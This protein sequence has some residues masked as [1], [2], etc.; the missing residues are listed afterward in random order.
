MDSVMSE[1]KGV[2]LYRE[3][4]ELWF[5]AGMKMHKWLSNSS[6]VMK[7]IRTSGRQIEFVNYD[8]MTTV[9]FQQRL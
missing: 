1:A 3:L 7:E 8:W 4:C 9:C 5:K 2:K 6:V